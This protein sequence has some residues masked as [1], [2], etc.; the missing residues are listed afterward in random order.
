M[1]YVVIATLFFTGIPRLKVKLL[2]PPA[3][4]HQR[5]QPLGRAALSDQ[6]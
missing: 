5:L 2:R 6:H 3:S 1:L 4:T